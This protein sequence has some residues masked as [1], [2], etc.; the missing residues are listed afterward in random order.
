MGSIGVALAPHAGEGQ[1]K[2]H[3]H[4]SNTHNTSVHAVLRYSAALQRTTV[5]LA[6]TEE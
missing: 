1:V 2:W 6:A 3:M 5:V 4:N